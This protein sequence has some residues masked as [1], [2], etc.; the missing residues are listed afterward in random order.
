[1]NITAIA[2]SGPEA[3]QQKVQ[4]VAKRIASTGDTVDLSTEM[5]ALLDAKNQ[6]AANAKVIKTTRDIDL[7]A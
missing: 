2:L 5:V 3:A 7:F 6:Y 1:M 4:S